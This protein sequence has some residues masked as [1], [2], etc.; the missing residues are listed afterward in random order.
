MQS[1]PLLSIVIPTKGRNQYLLS[2][3]E[4]IMSL[5]INESVEVVVFDTNGKDQLSHHLAIYGDRVKHIFAPHIS[6]FS[7]TFDAAIAHAQGLYVCAIG[8]D[9]GIIP[10]VME[11]IAY[12]IKNNIDSFSSSCPIIY[13]WPDYMHSRRGT[14][15]AGLLSIR[16]FDLTI[17]DINIE[18]EME[19][20]LGRGFQDF[21]KLPR[22]YYGVVRNSK[23]DYIR[24]RF[25]EIFSSSSPD[26]SSSIMLSMNVSRHILISDPI[27]IAGSSRNSGAGRSA[28]GKHSGSLEN[29]PWMKDYI[30]QWPI[31]I[32][33]IF[34]PET[35]WAHSGY[36][37]LKIYDKF[38]LLR[39]MDSNYL[40]AKVM[41]S[42]PSLTR[43][44]LNFVRDRKLQPVTFSINIISVMY[45]RFGNVLERLLH[46]GKYDYIYEKSDVNNVAIAMM[47]SY[48]EV[49]NVKKNKR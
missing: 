32:P 38:N 8:D 29:E 4:G 37:T 42:N 6:G 24:R 18:R 27:F 12:A 36:E 9:D 47:L 34:S 43:P 28:S 46:Y 20:L 25:S 44:I 35:M 40:A 33:R 26:I 3:V 30:D 19:Q 48:S 45:F 23:I 2:C 11:Y 31:E 10:T 13:R 21:S 7:R 15:D 17:S 14:T 22:L 16:N 5:F 49:L 1:V 41:I 39:K